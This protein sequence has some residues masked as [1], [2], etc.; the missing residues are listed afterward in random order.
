LAGAFALVLSFV[1][2]AVSNPV[3]ASAIALI[4]HQQ[5]F[6][7]QRPRAVYKR[8]R[9]HVGLAHFQFRISGR[10]WPCLSM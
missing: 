6:G 7:D 3:T 2:A 1:S 8:L 10:S 9:I 4:H 5:V